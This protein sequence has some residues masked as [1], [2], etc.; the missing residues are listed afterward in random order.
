MY[1]CMY[2]CVHECMHSSMHVCT[3]LCVCRYRMNVC[4]YGM[5]DG[6]R[7]GCVYECMYV[8]MHIYIYIC[9]CIVMICY[10]CMQERNHACRSSNPVETEVKLHLKS[11]YKYLQIKIRAVMGE[12]KRGFKHAASTWQ[13]RLKKHVMCARVYVSVWFC[14]CVCLCPV[15]L[16]VFVCLWNIWRDVK[17]PCMLVFLYCMGTLHTIRDHVQWSYLTVWDSAWSALR[18]C[19]NFQCS[20]HP[21]ASGQAQ[22]RHI[23]FHAITVWHWLQ[24]G[25]CN[26]SYLQ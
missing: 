19:T 4:V 14:V 25:F 5:M 11:G 10:A 9:I 18:T 6:C 15:C 24:F 20:W 7:Y 12:S 1:V 13:I 22:K 23:V 26:R 21:D 3:T 2:V 16:C 8:G 17:L